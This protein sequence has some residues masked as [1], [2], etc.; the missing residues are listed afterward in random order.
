MSSQPQPAGLRNKYVSVQRIKTSSVPDDSGHIVEAND[1]NWETFT[2]QWV[3]VVPRGSRE[4][5]RGE[6]VAADITHQVEGLLNDESKL[7]TTGQRIIMDGRRLNIAEPPRN[8]DE[9]D[10]SLRFACVE[11]K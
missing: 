7:M 6:Q 4:F 8:V 1:A 9:Q 11:V 3:S 5:F 2:H 10:H